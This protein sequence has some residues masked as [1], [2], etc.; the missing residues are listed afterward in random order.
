[1]AW[2][3]LKRN[4]GAH[5]NDQFS[6]DRCPHLPRDGVHRRA[7]PI[8]PGRRHDATATTGLCPD[9]LR[10]LAARVASAAQRF[11]GLVEMQRRV[12]L[13]SPA[14]VERRPAPI[15]FL[16]RDGPARLSARL[17]ASYMLNVL[18]LEPWVI[19]EQLRH[20]DG[21]ALVLELYGHPIAR[22]RS[23]ASGRPTRGG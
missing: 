7:S 15:V 8:P 6:T 21:G 17:G 2:L 10:L 23:G 11:S 5:L 14:S 9:T 20:S 3:S 22:R 12:A 19:A 13:F 16:R 4:G 18:A 1:M